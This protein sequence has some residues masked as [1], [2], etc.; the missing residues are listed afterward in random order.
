[1]NSYIESLP[2]KLEQLKDSPDTKVVLVLGNESCDLDSAVCALVLAHHQSCFSGTFALPILNIPKEDVILKTE[3]KYC[4]GKELIEKIPARDDI[5]F[6]KLTCLQ[7]ELVDHHKIIQELDFLSSKIRKIVDHRQLDQ[8]AIFP[9]SCHTNVQ[10]VGSCATL[11]AEE[12][13]KDGYKDAVGL[14]LLRKAIIT[15][16]VNF[17]PCAQKFTALDKLILTRIE[18]ALG[19]PNDQA[20]G[21]KEQDREEIFQSINTAKRSTEGFSV[22]Q[23]IN[24]D[25]KMVTFDGTT[26]AAVSSTYPNL[27]QDLCLKEG[28]IQVVLKEFLEKSKAQLLI[29]I[30]LN[31]TRDAMDILLFHSD[32]NIV[33]LVDAI[34]DAL[35]QRQ[36]IQILKNPAFN[37]IIDVDHSCNATHLTQGNVSYTR[38]KLLPKMKYV[39]FR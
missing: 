35:C 18:A 20:P 36:E 32:K 15:D 9:Q 38:K 22:H 16:T 2:Y 4:V 12:V 34:V 7:L 33:R 37:K 29:V 28:N 10:L 8:S 3:V 30:G 24:K 14:A 27:A 39:Y 1:M 11:V 19:I 23:L 13:L 31:E 26:R 17:S 25:L 21:E 6:R 5:D